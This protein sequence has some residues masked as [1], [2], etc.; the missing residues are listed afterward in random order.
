MKVRVQQVLDFIYPPFC[1]ACRADGAWFCETC[2]SHVLRNASVGRPP[3]GF[4]DFYS[5]GRYADPVLR[6]LIHTLKYRAASCCLKS[7]AKLIT[8]FADTHILFQ[9]ILSIEGLNV[10]FVPSDD[11][12][13]RERGI[14]HARLLAE[15]F[16]RLYPN[17]V[18]R[19]SLIK[20]HSV[21]ANASL[22]SNAA[23]KGNTQDAFLAAE[24]VYGPCLL[25]DDVYTTGATL[26]ACRSALRKAGARKIYGFT[27]AR[28]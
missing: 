11:L 4:E 20:R 22:P 10:F 9:H 28:K 27:L 13:I 25:I 5:I 17:L 3:E 8:E 26:Q 2:R 18:L 12:R 24:Q 19:D 16:A 21:M 6:R 14:D 15:T 7:I 1:I 23:R